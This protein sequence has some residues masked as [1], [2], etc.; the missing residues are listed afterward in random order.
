MPVAKVQGIYCCSADDSEYSFYMSTSYGNK[1]SKVYRAKYNP[2]HEKCSFYEKKM[3]GPAGFED[4]TM[5]DDK[6]WCVSESG[7]R[8]YQKRSLAS[9]GA[10]PWS[11]FFPY[12][13]NLSLD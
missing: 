13:F 3:T 7:A 8:Y 12:V 1:S 2:E 9:S 10:S 11:Q 5:I 4:L 6:V